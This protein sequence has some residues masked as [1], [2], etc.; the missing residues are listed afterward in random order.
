MPG[1]EKNRATPPRLPCS[2]SLLSPLSLSLTCQYLDAHRST[3]EVSPTFRSPSLYLRVRG[4]G[5]EEK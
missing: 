1:Q 2:L 4:G 5:E 3:Q